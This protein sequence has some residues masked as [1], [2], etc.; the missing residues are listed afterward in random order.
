MVSIMIIITAVLKGEFRATPDHI[1]MIFMIIMTTIIIMNI[2]MI[3]IMITFDQC[4]LC[5]P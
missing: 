4:E 1:D 5:L 2:T 3:T